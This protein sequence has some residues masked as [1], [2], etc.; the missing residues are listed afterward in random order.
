MLDHRGV[1]VVNEVSG[2]K[3]LARVKNGQFRIAWNGPSSSNSHAHTLSNAF[4]SPYNN[5]FALLLRCGGHQPWYS[6][7]SLLL[8]WML[9]NFTHDDS[10]TKFLWMWLALQSNSSPWWC[11]QPCAPWQATGWVLKIKNYL[12]YPPPISPG[13]GQ[14]D[15]TNSNPGMHCLLEKNWKGL[16]R[17]MLVQEFCTNYTEHQSLALFVRAQRSTQVMHEIFARSWEHTSSGLLLS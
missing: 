12:V 11:N 8:G 7:M 4:T 5:T 13:E 17:L 3:A 14:Q 1:C 2:T 15:P 16:Y 10:S 6:M 9:S